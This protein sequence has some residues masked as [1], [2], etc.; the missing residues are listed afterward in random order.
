MR[1]RLC[2]RAG[3]G[4]TTILA[5]RLARR[6]DERGALAVFMAFVLVVL[7]GVS[8]LV[9]DIGLQ[10]VTRSD[11]QAVADVVA[12]DLA[13]QL[14]GRSAAE[15]EPVVAAQA[16]ISL[17][18]NSE[19]IGDRPDLEV[20]LGR[21]DDQGDF[22]P[23][24][25]GQVP[26]AV[27]VQAEASVGF[28]FAGITGVEEG[29]ADRRAVTTASSNG[30]FRLG[31][32]AAALSTGDSV[33]ADV[34]ESLMRDP[35]ALG[36]NLTGVGYQGLLTSYVGLE[37]LAVE[38]DAGT[39]DALVARGNVSVA[40]LLAASAR[41]LN[42]Q[43]DV[44]AG[45]ILGSIAA[46]VDGGVTADLGDILDVGGGSALESRINT[47]DLIGGA[48]LSAALASSVADHN[49]L[50][51]TG[52]TWAEPH[53]SNGDIALTVIEPPRQA[54]AAPGSAAT[55][56]T[57]QIKLAAQIGFALPN[58]V[59]GLDVRDEA[60]PSSMRG[61]LTVDATIAGASA[62]LTGLTCEEA[63]K[64]FRMRVDSR[65][66]DLR[67]RMPFRLRGE[68]TG[69]SLIESLVPVRF[70]DGLLTRLLS[71]ELDISLVTAAVLQTA[72]GTGGGD[73]VYGVP[74]H[75][76]TDPQPSVGSGDLV[77]LLKPRVQVGTG[78]QVVKLKLSGVVVANLQLSDLNLSVLLDAVTSSVIGSSVSGVVDNF[79]KALVP[80][81]QLLGLRVAGAD[82]FGVPGPTCGIPRLVG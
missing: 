5:P 49:N 64:E 37:Q 17:D 66:V 23:V 57:G 34:F 31:S 18:R 76:Y 55:A 52:V 65:L 12:L 28:A 79:N 73:T 21:V 39:V 15:L 30:C 58:K 74:P 20:V 19:S 2:L 38:M 72:G 40:Q 63:Y 68:L 59:L 45:A 51:S 8:A 13:R 47:V 35:D 75:D 56:S 48:A 25:G 33:I 14:D 3:R 69:A 43:G 26:T 6:R 50:L 81:A 22:V 70:R 60:D 82:V 46:K 1:H 32:F 24:S 71:L 10:R 27:R 54:C 16:Q 41:V 36:V 61:A 42:S 29:D 7:L 77:R 4:G 78:T 44:S 80:V 67:V 62:V 11:M 9:I 53:T